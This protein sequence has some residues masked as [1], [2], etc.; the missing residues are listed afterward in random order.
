MCG[1]SLVVSGLCL[2]LSSYA[3]NAKKTFIDMPDSLCPLLTHNNRADCI[4]FLNSHMKAKVQNRFDSISEMTEMS[5]DYIRVR[6]SQETTWQMKLLTVNDSTKVICVVSTAC[7]PACDSS[8]KFYSTSW[9]E[10]S[11][12]DKSFINLPQL[13]DFF[14]TPSDSLSS[15]QL[16]SVRRYADMLLVRADFNASDD[17]LTFTFTTPDYM[18]KGTGDKLRLFIHPLSYQWNGEQF[19]KK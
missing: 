6:L 12:K 13:N 15:Y 2:P 14:I 18:D 10:I 8:L 5:K 9:K 4:D 19:L 7:A 16:E 11:S 17:A 3:Q 1:I